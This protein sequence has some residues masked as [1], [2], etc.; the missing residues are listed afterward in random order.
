MSMFLWRSSQHRTCC[1][2][3]HPPVAATTAASP[4]TPPSSQARTTVGRT[5]AASY[6]PHNSSNDNSSAPHGRQP[7]PSTLTLAT[8][9]QQPMQQSYT[10]EPPVNQWP[11]Q[12]IGPTDMS[13]NSSFGALHSH[14]GAQSLADYRQYLRSH[15][16]VQTHFV[17]NEINTHHHYVDPGRRRM[18]LPGYAGDVVQL[19]AYRPMSDYVDYAPVM[20][21][22]DETEVVYQTRRA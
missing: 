20:M 15:K 18:L 19:R 7:G 22:S 10:R 5:P 8:R 9:P 1:S 11:H 17:P 21:I 14:A 12:A 13:H 3:H 6:S 4:W 2:P 16:R